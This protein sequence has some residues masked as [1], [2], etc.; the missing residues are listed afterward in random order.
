MPTYEYVCEA[1]DNRFERI[2]PIDGRDEP[3]QEPCVVCSTDAV[4][5]IAFSAPGLC[6]KGC[7]WTPK[8]YPG[9]K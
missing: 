3:T 8:F 9:V 7:G 2:L 4:T 5:R 6:K 1:C